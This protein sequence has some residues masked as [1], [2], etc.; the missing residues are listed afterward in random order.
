MQITQHPPSYKPSYS[1]A[2]L[3]NYVV[4][5]AEPTFS[6]G[7]T[8]HTTNGGVGWK[9]N[10]ALLAM[11]ATAVLSPQVAAA[12]QTSKQNGVST[13][14]TTSLSQFT[15]HVIPKWETL[16][17][18]DSGSYV[19]QAD[20]VAPEKTAQQKAKQEVKNLEAKQEAKKLEAKRAIQQLEQKKADEKHALQ[21]R[22]A[23]KPQIC[24]LSDHEGGGVV[25]V[26]WYNWATTP[27]SSGGGGGSRGG[28][29]LG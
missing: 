4:Q 17:I 23:N 12:S 6:G 19:P 28:S 1:K 24:W 21:K 7:G 11:A 9:T 13:T 2:L 3:Q 27:T 8:S 14:T 15:P 22:D 29:G 16:G 26:N 10:F 20:V 25:F 18:A 5:H